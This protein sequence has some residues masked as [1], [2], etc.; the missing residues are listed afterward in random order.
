M[1]HNGNIHEGTQA[2]KMVFNVSEGKTATTS[3]DD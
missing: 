3:K 2:V 1:E